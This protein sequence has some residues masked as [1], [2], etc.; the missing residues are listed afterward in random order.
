[1]HF[2]AMKPKHTTEGEIEGQR[3][4]TRLETTSRNGRSIAPA[5]LDFVTICST[6]LT[7]LDWFSHKSEVAILD[8]DSP[9]EDRAKIAS[10]A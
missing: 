3:L 5:Y 4:D 8:A 1:M 2:R 10:Q 9:F 6:Q 7:L